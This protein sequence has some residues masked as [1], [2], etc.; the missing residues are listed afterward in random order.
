[1]NTKENIILI[2]GANIETITPDSSEYQLA[3]ELLNDY[4]I[5]DNE[6]GEPVIQ[7][8]MNERDFKTS[9]FNIGIQRVNNCGYYIRTI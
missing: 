3:C 1:M 2:T 5:M 8:A 6:N 4:N 7:F 9:L